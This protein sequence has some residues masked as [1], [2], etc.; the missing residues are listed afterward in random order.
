MAALLLG[1]LLCFA[2]LGQKQSGREGMGKK[3]GTACFA[4]ATNLARILD[5]RQ[6]SLI[7]I[8]WCGRV[9]V[10]EV[11]VELDSFIKI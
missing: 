3:D 1:W 11:I 7:L 6:D 2:V 10:V 9:A 4:C 8:L 5:G